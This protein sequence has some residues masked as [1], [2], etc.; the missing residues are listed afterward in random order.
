MAVWCTLLLVFRCTWFFVTRNT[1]YLWLVMGNYLFTM[2]LWM[3]IY[4]SICSSPSSP[5]C[6]SSNPTLPST[7]ESSRCAE[8]RVVLNRTACRQAGLM[9]NM[10]DKGLHPLLQVVRSTRVL[11]LLH[12]L[13][14]LQ[15]NIRLQVT[16]GQLSCSGMHYF[17][18]S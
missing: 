13:R 4:S 8:L 11:H 9:G 10:R 5:N 2:H 6:F 16:Y 15:P 1:R 12:D 7:W 3:S 18:S 14:Y 17:T